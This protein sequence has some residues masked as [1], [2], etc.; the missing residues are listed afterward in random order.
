MYFL[1]C[2]TPTT[3]CAAQ[4]KPNPVETFR[5]K[6]VCACA[7]LDALKSFFKGSIS[8]AFKARYRYQIISN[9]PGFEPIR[10]N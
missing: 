6:Q 10:L 5:W 7:D 4:G 8:E 3:V 1:E 2:E 9:T